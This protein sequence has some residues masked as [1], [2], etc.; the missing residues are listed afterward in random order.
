MSLPPLL[1]VPGLMCDGTVWEPLLPELAPVADCRIVDH[2]AADSITAMA[3]RLLADAPPVF[4]LAGHSMGGRVALEVVRLAPQRVTR[5]AL[6]DTG[7]RAR[8]PGAAGEE[9]ARKRHTLLD[10][11]RNRGVRAMAQQWVQGMVHP[12]RLGDAV[13]IE[14]IVAMFERRTADIFEC[15]IR[16]LLGRPDATPVLA[17]LALPT[18]VLCGRQDSWAPLAQHEEL[19]ALIPARPPVRVI[20]DAGHMSTMERPRAVAQALLDWL[21]QAA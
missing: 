18:L 2:G 11:A 15:Q 14:A 17:S 13:L 5:L 3:Q 20:E 19:A 8:A 12:A 16:A 7:Y 6:L 9:E 1:L 21:G 4:A 10:V